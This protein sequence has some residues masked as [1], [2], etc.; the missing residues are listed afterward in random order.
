MSLFTSFVDSADGMLAPAHTQLL[1]H[2][3][4]HFANCGQKPYPTV[5]QHLRLCLTIVL[6][7]A[8]H[9]CLRGLRKKC[10]I[11]TPCFLALTPANPSPE[12]SM[13]YG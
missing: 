7:Q 12:F 2:L 1:Q 5:M 11:H 8:V 10:L 6:V 4:G 3:A 9:H 13:M